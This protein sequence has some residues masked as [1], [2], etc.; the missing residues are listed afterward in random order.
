MQIQ[1]VKS[2]CHDENQHIHG[3]LSG[4]E[5][6]PITRVSGKLAPEHLFLP[7][8]FFLN[9]RVGLGF[10][11]PYWTHRKIS[12]GGGGATMAVPSLPTAAALP[13]RSGG[14]AHMALNW[15][16][17]HLVCRSTFT[18]NSES[19]KNQIFKW[20]FWMLCFCFW[21]SFCFCFQRKTPLVSN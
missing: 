7:P 19:A 17:N 12:R 5:A 13:A 8:G 11:I 16:E 18:Q 3:K 21:F 1:I 10:L 4:R 15:S 20:T 6:A 2:C 14:P 9:P